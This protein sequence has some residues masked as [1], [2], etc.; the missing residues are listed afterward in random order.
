MNKKRRRGIFFILVCLLFATEVFP[1]NFSRDYI[2]RVQE[3]DDI[4]YFEE[5][6]LEAANAYSALLS[7]NPGN[8][9]LSYKLGVCYLNI[10]GK[11]QEALVLLKTAITRVVKNDNEYLEYGDLSPS[12]TRFYLANAY[13]VN[14][15]LNQAIVQY[16]EARKKLGS[17]SAFRL[18]YINNEIKACQNA[19]AQLAKP[20]EV[21]FDF[22]APVL[23]E[24]N[25]SGNPVVSLNDSTFIFTVG[26]GKSV[27]IMWSVKKSDWQKP[28]DI[29]DQLGKFSNLIPN[30]IS[31]DGKLLILARTTETEGDLY[32]SE[33]IG[34]K[35]SKAKSLGSRI[36][37]PYWEEFG[38]IQP[39]GKKI[40]FTSNRPGGMGELDIWVSEIDSKGNWSDPKNLGRPV[41]SPYNEST[42]FFDVGS[43]KLWFSSIGH[44]GIGNYDLY[45]STLN[46]N[47]WTKPIAMPYPINTT[48]AD[49]NLIPYK[50]STNFINA[51]F[52]PRDHSKNVYL[53]SMKLDTTGNWL[54]AS[55]KIFLT[56]GAVAET[57]QMVVEII[58]GDSARVGEKLI[59]DKE[60]VFTTT[61]SN[62]DTQIKVS[63]EGYTSDTIDIPAGRPAGTISLNT[64]LIPESVT[65]GEFLTLRSIL[66]DFDSYKLEDEGIH[67]IEKIRA[68][69]VE[70]P[71]LRIQ[72]T[73]YT[74][75]KG[76]KEYNLRLAARRV[77]A[78]VEQFRKKGI[79]SSR[80]EIK[81]AG[82]TD[83]V[84][85]N[86]KPD[87]SDNPE[88][89]RYNRRVTMGVINPGA[90]LVLRQ[91]TFTPAH[92][93]SS[94][95]ERYSIVLLRSQVKY[96]PDYFRNMKIGELNF[97]RPVATDSLYYYL[98]GDFSDYDEA[99][100][101]L[102]F[103]RESG[104]ADSFII[105]QFDL[106]AVQRSNK[107]WSKQTTSASQVPIY[108]VQLL[109]SK[110]STA[111][112]LKRVPE[113]KVIECKDHIYRYIYGEYS[114][115]SQARQA[116]ANLIKDGYKDAFIREIRSL[117]AVTGKYSEKD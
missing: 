10:E 97:V 25:N 77:S 115:F 73:G 104:F 6:F 109:A 21:N 46:N 7:E 27:R 82:A 48:G 19:I 18:D 103:S 45:Y 11:K 69:L 81:A 62:N 20:A 70:N 53:L 54:A 58:K 74:D 107:P 110:L 43:N 96:Y 60:G 88:G 29:T 78:V 94:H 55:G 79:E 15:S 116:L 28:V 3:A 65:N 67:E 37:S 34:K 111:S 8:P 80:F 113:I 42:P 76:T 87:G 1:Q 13:H 83:F 117:D 50:S 33:L 100:K 71:S 106:S 75:S 57:D 63:Y 41:N 5:N 17:S 32:Y 9:N 90:G 108:T 89:R 52:T 85:D 105:N 98:L 49:L 86:V 22:F 31:K 36:N 23:K 64:N 95:A 30:S 61:L 35:W 47:R 99:L 12:E 92:L 39:D 26:S 59:P 40:F 4:F 38:F 114:G 112:I 66:F 84:A 68:L 93:R 44:E 102:E 16:N 56:D 14:D 91:P 2:R 24:Y 72:I 101:A 51:R